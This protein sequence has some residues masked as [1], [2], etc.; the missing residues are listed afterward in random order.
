MLHVEIDKRLFEKKVSVM[1]LERAMF[2]F[3]NQA[4][5]DMNRYVPK[6][7]GDLRD[8]SHVYKNRISYIVPYANYQYRGISSLGN[9]LSKYSTPGTGSHW[10]KRAKANHLSSWRK[11]FVKGG[12]F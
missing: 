8:K 10:D 5:A 11:A 9:K 1:N 12:G 2:A 3:T 7:S 4:H 6:L